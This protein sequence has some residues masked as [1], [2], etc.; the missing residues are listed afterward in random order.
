MH[1]RMACKPAVYGYGAVCVE[2]VPHDKQLLLDLT[3]QPAQEEHN[4]MGRDVGVGVE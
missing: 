1:V 3:C 2:P 4:F